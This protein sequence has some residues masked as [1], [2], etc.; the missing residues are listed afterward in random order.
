MHM[1]AGERRAAAALAGIFSFRMLGL[2]MILPVFALY[3]QHLEGVTPALMG[4]AIGIYGLTQAALQIPFGMA[5][6]HWG[7]KRVIAVGLLL[8][9]VGSMIAA[10]ADTIT[11]VIIGR[12]VQGAGAVAAAIM[13]LL[14]DLTRDE[15]R[16]KAMAFVG[17]SIGMSFLAAMVAGPVLNDWIGVPG[18]FGATAILAL[19]GIAVLYLLVPDPVTTR[20]HRDLAPAPAQFRRVLSDPELL[21]ADIG[22]FLLH[23]TMTA[24]FVALPLA[25]RDA[26]LGAGD[27]WR[28]YLPVMLL[29]IAV[30]VPFI[31]IAER[32]RAMKPVLIGAVGLLVLG[33]LGLAEFHGSVL[34]LALVVWVYFVGFN[35]L[36]AGLPSLVSKLAPVEG[37][38]TAMGVYSSSQFLGAFVGGWAGG[39]MFGAYGF[40]GLFLASAAVLLIWLG[41]V[42]T[43]R[44]PRHLSTR[45]L[46][47]REVDLPGMTQL[48]LELAAV[49][50]VAEVAVNVE[51]RTAYLKVDSEALDAA[52]LGR[53]SRGL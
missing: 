2:F 3:A 43:M 25:L 19:A 46:H 24:S 21:R 52:A 16:T 47:L 28:V 45:V 41:L 34:G 20:T 11:G 7:R 5:S 26:G 49:P 40:E 36:E 31:I 48:Q 50:G 29:A 13:A 23:M 38:G 27:H 8:F 33:E 44:R 37:K 30:A 53:F 42:A 35:L 18:I 22:I 6:D 32:K 4:M 12:A 15:N 9:A 14:A 17:M 1:S 39:W 10:S 51:D